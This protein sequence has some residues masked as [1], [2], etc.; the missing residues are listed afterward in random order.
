[1]SLR[2]GSM[3]TKEW[4][5][6]ETT[7]TAPDGS[8]RVA[9]DDLAFFPIAARDVKRKLTGFASI[10]PASSRKGAV[11]LI[12][13]PECRVSGKIVCDELTAAGKPIGWANA[14][15]LYGGQRIGECDNPGGFEFNVPPGRYTLNVYGENLKDKYVDVTVPTGRADFQ[16]SPAISLL[17]SRLTRLEGQPAPEL[18]GVVGWRGQPLKLADLHG[19]YVLIDFW[20]YWCGPCVHAMP[21]LVDLHERFK[22]KGLAIIGVHCDMDGE[23][24]TAAKYDEKIA[25]IK[26]KIWQGKDL[27]FPVALTTKDYIDGRQP[28]S[29]S[30]AAQYGIL[31]Y[32]T[33]IL[34]DKEGKVVGEFGARDLK[35][36][37]AEIEKLLK[38]DR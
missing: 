6:Q 7:K 30:S 32:P 12:L 13:Q 20:G 16:I 3:N 29:R 5:Y 14:Y 28:V 38:S 1:M 8:A 35:Q 11:H 31:H 10:S 25:P 27:P 18:E 33:T 34:I 26:K 2:R 19:K 24:D 36:A 23:V 9:Y 17:A 4:N 21:V 15:L 22:D 37:A